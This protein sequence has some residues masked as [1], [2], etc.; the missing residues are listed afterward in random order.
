MAEIGTYSV[1][2]PGG[3]YSG[4]TVAS[5][6]STLD[7]LLVGLIDNDSG[8]IKARNIRDSVYT[9]WD[10]VDSISA[11]VSNMGTASFLYERSTPSSITSAIGGVQPGA[12]F[13]G[14]IQDVL[15]RIFY[16]Y[17]AP[18]GSISPSLSLEY[19][20]PS[21]YSFTLNWSV[22][23][24]SNNITNITYNSSPTGLITGAIPPV[25]GSSQTG[26]LNGFGTHSSSNPP[27]STTNTYTLTVSDGTSTPSFSTS[28]NW[29]NRIYWGRIDLSSLDNPDLTTN[30]G[31]IPAVSNLIT[32][33]LIRNLSGAGANGIADVSGNGITLGNGSELSTS[34]SKTY[35]SINGSGKHLIFAWPSNVGGAYT[36]SWTV[37]GLPQSAFTRLKTNWLFT[38]QFGFSGSN[39][40]VWVSNTVQNSPLTIVV[41]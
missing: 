37:G 26:T 28:L 24:K 20:N 21:G 27:T 41:S 23:K 4:I 34:K 2:G 22:V 31:S 18:S 8:L 13:S 3:T 35:T 9:L 38:N 16:P 14:S 1:G 17:V 7:E 15:D 5:E 33:L 29:R 10:R 6:F 12:T 25:T 32:W 40:E 11:T 30:P 19:G 36:P 39:Y